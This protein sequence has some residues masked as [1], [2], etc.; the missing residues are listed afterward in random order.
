MS[1]VVEELNLFSVVQI[2][3]AYIDLRIANMKSVG[4]AKQLHTSLFG[5]VPLRF[6]WTFIIPP[7][8][9]T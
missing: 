9:L 7:A 2:P 1:I 4:P 3:R 8:G 5:F 6:G